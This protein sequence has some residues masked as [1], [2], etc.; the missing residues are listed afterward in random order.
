MY[1]EGCSSLV[2]PMNGDVSTFGTLVGYP[3]N[4][5]Y[6]TGS[7]ASYI[8][9]YGYEFSTFDDTTRYCENGSWSG[10]APIC[11]LIGK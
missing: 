1:I 11:S 5:L 2:A 8:C 6:V 10:I 9:D 4:F 3:D 7:Y